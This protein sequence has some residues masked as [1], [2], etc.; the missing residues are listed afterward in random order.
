[1]RLIRSRRTLS[2]PRLLRIYPQSQHLFLFCYSHWS[3]SFWLRN[4]IPS[5]ARGIRIMVWFMMRCNFFLFLYSCLLMSICLF[6]FDTTTAVRWLIDGLPISHII[7][8][9][10][11]PGSECHSV[12]IDLNNSFVIHLLFAIARISLVCARW[13]SVIDSRGWTFQSFSLKCI[14]SEERYVVFFAARSHCDFS[15]CITHEGNSDWQSAETV[16]S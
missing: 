4:A 5:L 9:K 3:V 14:L 8:L 10:Y 1:M 13:W 11:P 16:T 7:L 6:F 2:S 12:G 15:C